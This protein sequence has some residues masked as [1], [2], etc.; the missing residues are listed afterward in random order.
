[1]YNIYK[2]NIKNMYK[3]REKLSEINFVSASYHTKFGSFLKGKG[4]ETEAEIADDKVDFHDLSTN[5][6]LN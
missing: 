4:A 3:E 5:K 6:Q 1:M 2:I